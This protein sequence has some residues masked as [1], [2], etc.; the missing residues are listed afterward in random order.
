VGRSTL[1]GRHALPRAFIG[2]RDGA[3]RL[4]AKVTRYRLTTGRQPARAVR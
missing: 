1:D 2:D 3:A 4:F